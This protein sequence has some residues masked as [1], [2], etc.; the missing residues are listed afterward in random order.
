MEYASFDSTIYN[1]FY[2]G[3]RRP[4]A[5]G[6]HAGIVSPAADTWRCALGRSS[7]RRVPRNVTQPIFL[8]P[9]HEQFTYTRKRWHARAPL[10]SS[11]RS[12]YGCR[13]L[14]RVNKFISGARR[15][16]EISTS[17]TGIQW[18]STTDAERRT[19]RPS[20]RRPRNRSL[21]ETCA[22]KFLLQLSPDVP[23][24]A[25]AATRHA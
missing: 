7:R 21:R 18:N 5:A 20:R 13:L 23:W 1:E 2:C 6:S 9:A 17:G 15:S 22:S 10:F 8:F 11:L 4:R 14:A 24:L 19:P 12:L 16:V 3:T 25:D